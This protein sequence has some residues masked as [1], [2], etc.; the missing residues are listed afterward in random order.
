VFTVRFQLRGATLRAKA[1]AATDT[2]PP[3][4]LSVTDTGLT[5]PGSVGVRS[6]LD[7]ANTNT[8]PV[9]FTYDNFQVIN[10]QTFTV[11]RSINGVVKNHSAGEDLR[12]A[13]P[14]VLGL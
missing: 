13:N 4:Q 3:W 8:L 14:T 2:E 11:T 1:W 7:S 6:T 10:P 9:T 5:A 12:L